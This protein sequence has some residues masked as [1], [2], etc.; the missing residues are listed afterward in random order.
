MFNYIIIDT[1]S[2]FDLENEISLYIFI[3]LKIILNKISSKNNNKFENLF[4][5]KSIK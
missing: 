3:T 2:L 5:I 1:K 4:I